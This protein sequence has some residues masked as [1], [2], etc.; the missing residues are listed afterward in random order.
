MRHHWPGPLIIFT[1]VMSLAACTREKVNGSD[2]SLAS[3]GKVHSNLV[4][5]TDIAGLYAWPPVQGDTRGRSLTNEKFMSG[6]SLE[7]I[8]VSLPNEGQIWL[9]G[10]SQGHAL[11]VR[12]RTANA[13]LIARGELSNNW[14]HAEVSRADQVAGSHPAK[15]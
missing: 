1:A 8:K 6:Q 7:P 11:V 5:C 2:E 15:G 12:T 10:V 3:F 14:S 4:G 13:G 9:S